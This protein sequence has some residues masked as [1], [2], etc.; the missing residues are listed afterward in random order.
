MVDAAALR[1]QWPVLPHA[2]G[3]HFAV[4]TAVRTG[5][6]SVP[7]SLYDQGRDVCGVYHGM[8]VG[9]KVTAPRVT[10]S[11]EVVAKKGTRLLCFVVVARTRWSF[12]RS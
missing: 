12:G 11:T 4:R 6:R 1:R 9:V 2:Y 10:T 8:G 7:L 3:T 5:S